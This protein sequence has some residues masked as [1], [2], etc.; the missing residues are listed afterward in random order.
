MKT[1][2]FII[3]LALLFSVCFGLNSDRDQAIAY[4]DAFLDVLE[5]F[6][7]NLSDYG[8]GGEGDSWWCWSLKPGEDIEVERMFYKGNTYKL[9]A[10]GDDDAEDVDIEVYDENWNLIAEDDDIDSAAV[11]QF[12]PAWSG[13]FHI[14]T[15]YYDGNGRAHVGFFIAF[16]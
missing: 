11:V 5:V 16:Q 7:W 10:C 12:S 15:T 8:D 9:V 3:A 14:V 1:R 6:D 4:L 13:I 2:K